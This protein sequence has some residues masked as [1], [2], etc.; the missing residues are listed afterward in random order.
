MPWRRQRR[1]T[2][3]GAIALSI[4]GAAFALELEHGEF[5]SEV[6]VGQFGASGHFHQRHHRPI[7]KVYSNCR[8]AAMVHVRRRPAKGVNVLPSLFR[9]GKTVVF[10]RVYDILYNN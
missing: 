8:G 10:I 4:R 7:I 1:K 3:D 6:I 5:S 2:S 9:D